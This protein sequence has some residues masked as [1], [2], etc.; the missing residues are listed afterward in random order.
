M[1]YGFS[2]NTGG[3]SETK[4]TYGVDSFATGYLIHSQII[5][6]APEYYSS[7]TDWYTKSVYP[8]GLGWNIIDLTN[9][10]TSLANISTTWE[11]ASA[12][13]LS[14]SSL[15]P[16]LGTFQASGIAGLRAI[17]V[18]PIITRLTARS[19]AVKYNPMKWPSTNPSVDFWG[20][21]PANNYAYK[22]FWKCRVNFFGF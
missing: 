17:V 12:V 14:S 1:A 8:N 15:I 19:F 2:T 11:P 13:S 4:V 9:V 18:P 6:M 7:T 3:V 20:T 10:E 22:S 21:D 5:D 16:S